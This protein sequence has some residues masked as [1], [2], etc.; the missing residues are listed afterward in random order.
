MNK[1]VIYA[2]VS[3]KDQE[4]EGFSIPAQLK[5]LQEYASKNGY[6]IARE[7]IDAET[8]KKA[9]RKQFN[10]MLNF[11][12]EHGIKHLLVEKTD[13]LLRNMSDYVIIKKLFSSSDVSVHLAKENSILGKDAR[14]N[15]KFM[16]SIKAV[17]AESYIDILSEEVTKGMKEKAAQGTYPSLAP[18]GY[19]N[20]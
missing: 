9:G 17:M 11:I 12:A 6:S 20:A 8:A 10:L 7:F 13:R 4:S 1:A 14:S 3:S 18:Y 15:E 19:L 5:F 16:F 2:R